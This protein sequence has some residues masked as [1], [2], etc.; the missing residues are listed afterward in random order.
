MSWPLHIA[1]DVIIDVQWSSR[2]AKIHNKRFAGLRP[3]LSSLLDTEMPDEEK[4]VDE[5]L[6]R[7]AD[8]WEQASEMAKLQIQLL[9]QQTGNLAVAGDELWL[10]SHYLVFDHLYIHKRIMIK[11]P[12]HEMLTVLYVLDGQFAE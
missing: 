10:V 11:S 4:P 3:S 12:K 5:E 9:F 1:P 6:S 8:A 2:L 7:E